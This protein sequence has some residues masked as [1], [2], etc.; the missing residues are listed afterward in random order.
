MGAFPVACLVVAEEVRVLRP[1]GFSHGRWPLETLNLNAQ[2]HSWSWNCLID[3]VYVGFVYLTWFISMICNEVQSCISK[4]AA[5]FG[6]VRK[7]CRW[8]TIFPYRT[9]WHH[10][11]YYIHYPRNTFSRQDLDAWDGKISDFVLATW[12]MNCYQRRFRMAR[13]NLA[14]GTWM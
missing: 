9:S 12:H 1:D 2:C 14:N 7:V 5:H 4:L 3:M 13:S 11:M 8:L 6:W 10:D